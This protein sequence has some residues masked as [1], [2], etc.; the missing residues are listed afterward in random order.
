M[1]KNIRIR[2]SGMGGRF[3]PEDNFIIRVLRE[4]YD[5]II[6]DNPDYLFYSVNSKDYLDYNCI[7][8]FFTAENC[9]PDFNLCDYAIGFHNLQ[10]EDRYI[11]YPLYLVDDFNAYEGDDYKNDLDRAQV[12]H[13]MLSEVEKKDE[14]CSFIV[15]NGN[16]AE[17][18]Q[19]MFEAL[20]HYKKVNSGG[21]YMNNIGSPVK[22]KLMFQLK[23]KFVIA[24]ENSSTSGYTTEKIVHA[25]SAVAVPIY[26]GNPEIEKEFQKG[27]F[28]NCH[29]FGL[30]ESGEIEAI[31]SVVNEV[32]RIDQ[33]DSEYRK[34]IET[35]AFTKENDVEKS[36]NQ[37]KSFLYH[38]IDQELELAG[39]RNTS[40]YGKRYE[41][42]QK[43]GNSF[44]WVLRRL[45]PI[46]DFFRKI[47]G[48]E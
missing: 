43:I 15:S 28:V 44:Y 14:F 35:P 25:F 33:D 9:I 7:R 23:H 6:S 20:S 45:I 47:R 42:K 22:D 1:K 27:S 11:R 37:F 29:K 32:K 13:K 24:F 10:F 46:R 5:V 16:A 8:I 38:I 26:W 36:K 41:R 12:K 48:K 4:K 17:C 19:K 39:R 18:R 31:M 2:F 21:R 3:N 30:T 40:L 34:M